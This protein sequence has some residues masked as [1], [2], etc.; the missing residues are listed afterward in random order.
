MQE[1]KM[2][3]AISTFI[4]DN[5]DRV[6]PG[7]EVWAAPERAAVLRKLGLIDDSPALPPWQH[8][9]IVAAAAAPKPPAPRVTIV[10]TKARQGRHGSGRR[11]VLSL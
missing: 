8:P 4:N 5:G 6:E 10:P 1:S 9:V 11:L 7:A 2:A 3:K